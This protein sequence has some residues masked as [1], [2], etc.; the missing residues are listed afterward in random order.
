MNKD[1]WNGLSDAQRKAIEVSCADVNLWAIGTASGAQADALKAFRDN[2]VDVKRFPDS[3]I[4]A[5]KKATEEVY[6][7]HSA[8]DP[9][10]KKVMDSYQ[11]YSKVYDEYQALNSID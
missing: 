11:A 5:L 2:G 6:A 10:F 8:A 3:V 1:S 9:L 7:E 4:A